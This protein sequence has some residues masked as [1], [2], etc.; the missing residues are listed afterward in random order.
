MISDVAHLLRPIAA[1]GIATTLLSGCASVQKPEPVETVAPAQKIAPAPVIGRVVGVY[2][3]DTIT[4]LTDDK[5]QEKIRLI[6]ID[7][8]EKAQAFGDKSKTNLSRLIFDKNVKIEWKKRDKYKRIV[9]KVLVDE[10]DANLEQ[11]KTGFAWWYRDYARE[12]SPKD[13]E[14]YEIAEFEAKS[15]R[16]GLWADKNP[17][18][19]WEFRKSK[20]KSED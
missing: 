14:D 6:G 15:K 1:L 4:V 7:A 12:Q 2:D 16:L 5:T 3:G 8:P 10:T 11:V 9:G 13:R 17:V 20:G 19:P 18:P